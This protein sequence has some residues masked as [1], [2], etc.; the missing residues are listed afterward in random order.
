LKLRTIAVSWGGTLNTGNFENAKIELRLES[1]L[2]P[3]DDPAA[4]EADLW[5]RVKTAVRQQARPLVDA[6]KQGINAVF[7]GLPADVQKEIS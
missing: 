2:E 4:V 6:R 1:E 3:G 5:E 7:A